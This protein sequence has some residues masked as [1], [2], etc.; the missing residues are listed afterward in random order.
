MLVLSPLHEAAG[1]VVVGLWLGYVGYRI[2]YHRL[3]LWLYVALIAKIFAAWFFG[4]LY[5]SYYCHGDT[6]K[7]YLT[8]SR[9]AYYL[10]EVPADGLA[11]LFREL[12]P[13]WEAKGW[14]IFFQDIH[15]YGYDYEWSEPSSYFFY[16]LLLPLYLAGGGSYYGMQGL[17]AI[18]GGLLS[19]AAYRRWAQLSLFPSHFW[20]VWFL[21]PSGLLWTSGA[22]RDTFAVPLMLYGMAWIANVQSWRDL[23][24]L[25]ALLVLAA[26]RLEALPLAVV[27]GM[28]YRWGNLWLL[29]AGAGAAVFAL[30]LF[31]GPWAYAY[32]AEALLPAIHPDIADASTFRL[33]YEPSFWGSLIG[34]LRALPYGLLGPFPWQI[35]KPLVWL[36][37]IETWGMAGLG[38]YYA[39]RSTW[40]LRQ[41]LLILM[42]IFV[43]G[44]VAM[45]MPYWGT[46]ARQKLYGIY[47]M[48][49]GLGMVCEPLFKDRPDSLSES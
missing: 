15:L 45:A 21:L 20:V 34:W 14:R 2:E 9:L 41:I 19:Y 47:F 5:A 8:A 4:W 12:S 49:L 38:A 26:L 35:Q 37:G 43:I 48:A 40:G 6:L 22:L 3:P 28:L 25:L 46:L 18:T 30:G 31:I 17:T 39:W 36:Y 16:R 11:L 42:G 13:V 27:G 24:G 1:F 7:A 44:V 23:W 10:W 32:R 33:D 29:L